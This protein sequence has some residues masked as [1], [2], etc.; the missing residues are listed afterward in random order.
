MG[1]KSKTSYGKEGEISKKNILPG[2]MLRVVTFG[3]LFLGC[4]TFGFVI[5]PKNLPLISDDLN[6]I[7]EI[8]STDEQ[9]WPSIDNTWRLMS[10]HGSPALIDEQKEYAEKTIVSKILFRGNKTVILLLIEDYTINQI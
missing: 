1:I 8:F 3:L 9:L 2:K 6:E 7:N 10:I 4:Y 5:P